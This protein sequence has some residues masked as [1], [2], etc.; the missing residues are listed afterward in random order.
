MND[1]NSTYVGMI[2][3]K[4]HKHNLLDIEAQKVTYVGVRFAF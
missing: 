4:H 3:V 2:N 1:L